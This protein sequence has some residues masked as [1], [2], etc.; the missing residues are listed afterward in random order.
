MTVLWD[1]PT[2]VYIIRDSLPLWNVSLLM[3]IEKA[4]TVNFWL[5]QVI[6]L[7]FCNPII[8]FIGHFQRYYQYTV[9]ACNTES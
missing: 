2:V 9:S 4:L 1:F 3:I 5:L 7:L 8:I 6:V